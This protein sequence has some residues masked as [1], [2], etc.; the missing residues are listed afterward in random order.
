VQAEL[1]EAHLQ[2]V[3]FARHFVTAL[4]QAQRERI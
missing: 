1:V 3:D 4:G 2:L